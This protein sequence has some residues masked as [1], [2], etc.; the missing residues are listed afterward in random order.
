MLIPQ[1][2]TQLLKDMTLLFSKSDSESYLKKRKVPEYIRWVSEQSHLLDDQD[3]T[4]NKFLRK[5]RKEA[6]P[7]KLFLE[8]NPDL[9]IN[10]IQLS[11][12]NESWDA[13]CFIQRTLFSSRMYYI[14]VTGTR[15]Y[16]GDNVHLK[17]YRNPTQEGQNSYSDNAL[18]E[19]VQVIKDRI[20]KKSLNTHYDSDYILLV[21]C[22][23][24]DSSTEKFDLLIQTLMQDTAFKNDLASNIFKAIYIIQWDG[25]HAYSSKIK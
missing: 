2:V 20:E 14:E 16:N 6:F 8:K 22:E 5:L 17:I 19:D 24:N 7:I 25:Q 23:V 15:G 10:A 18:Q 9:N 1:K 11:Y 21:Y 4:K 12:S 3:E 13:M